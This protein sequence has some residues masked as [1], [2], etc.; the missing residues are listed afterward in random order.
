MAG[1]GG[2]AGSFYFGRI[3]IYSIFIG[4]FKNK[5]EYVAQVTKEKQS[6]LKCMWLFFSTV[7]PVF[8]WRYLIA[9]YNIIALFISMWFFVEKC[10]VPFQH[11]VGIKL[12]DNNVFISE[13]K[14]HIFQILSLDINRNSTKCL[15]KEIV[16]ELFLS[17]T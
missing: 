14:L 7:R 6:I 2:M 10:W 3:N 16:V 12:L 4:N 1:M 17:K 15:H 13:N 11:S 9:N 8:N 5:T